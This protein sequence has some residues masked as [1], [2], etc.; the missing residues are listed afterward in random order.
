MLNPE[1]LEE[2]DYRDF[3]ALKDIYD[4]ENIAEV[5]S[6]VKARIFEVL[7]KENVFFTT[8]VFFKPKGQKEGK[9]VFRPIHTARLID[10]VAMIAM[11]QILVY[12]I[13]T[14]GKFIPSELSKMI[15]SHFYGNRV[16]YDGKS[17]FKPWKEQYHEYTEKANEKLIEFS[18]SGEQ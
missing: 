4:E 18:H 15:P 13:G 12:E 1:L 14:D 8:R 6:Q 11:L 16:S 9:T 3:L 5:I 17:L 2:S 10:Q 7:D